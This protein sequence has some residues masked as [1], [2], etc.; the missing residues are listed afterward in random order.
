MGM[1]DV[2]HLALE[3]GDLQDAAVA[4]LP[5]DPGRVGKIA[6]RF[7][8][9]TQLAANREYTSALGHA[10]DARVVVCSTGIGGPHPW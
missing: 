2:F 6:E 5:G 9:Q 8:G 3:R 4:I 1:A 10:G 7:D